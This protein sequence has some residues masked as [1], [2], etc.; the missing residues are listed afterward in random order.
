MQ[1]VGQGPRRRW[2]QF[3]LRTLLVVSALVAVGLGEYRRRF[4]FVSKDYPVVDIGANSE[5]A[6]VAGIIDQIVQ[7]VEPDQ[8]EDVGGPGRVHLVASGTVL[9]VWQ[10]RKVQNGVALVLDQIR[11]SGG[12]ERVCR[13]FPPCCY[14]TC[15]RDPSNNDQPETSASNR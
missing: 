3:R 6:P 7:T 13:E 9:R 11:A 1:R 8:W 4:M 15:P 5:T 14:P 2:L 12:W 10:R